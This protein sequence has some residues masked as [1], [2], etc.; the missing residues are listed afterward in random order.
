MASIWP[1]AVTDPKTTDITP[2]RVRNVRTKSKAY[3]G[4]TYAYQSS[5]DAYYLKAQ[6]NTPLIKKIS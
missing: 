1:P 3:H 6:K 4:R 5:T 2:A